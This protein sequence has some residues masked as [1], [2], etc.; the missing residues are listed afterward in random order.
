MPELPDRFQPEAVLSMAAP[1]ADRLPKRLLYATSSGLGGTGLDSTSLEGALASQRGGFLKRVICYGVGSKRVPP[2]SVRSLQ[3]HPVRALSFLDSDEYYGAKKRYVDFISARDLR[4]GDYDFLHGWS[5]DCFRTLVEARIKGV[6]S[7]MDI[8]TW[9]RNKGAAKRGETRS[10]R[11][12]RLSGRS[13]REVLPIDRARMLAEYDL[14]DTILVASRK[15]A[16]TFLA[17][18]VPEKKLW[19]VARGV[20]VE[21]YSPGTPPEKLRFIFAGALIKRKGVHHLLEAWRKLHLRDAELV[22][23]GSLHDEIKPALEACGDDSVKH[24]GFSSRL[25]DELRASS[26]FVFPSECEG[27]AK[28]T[29]EAAACG[30]PLITTAESGD[31]A[32]DG[33]N[34]WIIPP[35]DVDALCAAMERAASD[36]SKL[37]EM[38]RNSRAR[39][40]ECLTWDHYR[41]RLLN[42]YA[43]TRSGKPA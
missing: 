22:L 20:D 2:S 15:A 6:P 40:L 10:E 30:L 43:R 14:C 36:R 8:P 9:H 34:G 38:G 16:E 32:V 26:V 5:G 11:E 41:L 13:W 31:A 25:Q 35:N 7:V 12:A 33:Y 4:R 23:V 19:Y 3:W 18:G 37:A 28:V 42:G 27:F 17:A 24:L 39:A 21:R 1:S 29:I